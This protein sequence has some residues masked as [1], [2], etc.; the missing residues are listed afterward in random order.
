MKK[1]KKR[2]DLCSSWT[3]GKSLKKDPC[4]HSNHKLNKKKLLFFFFFLFNIRLFYRQSSY[5]WVSH[6]QFLSAGCWQTWAAAVHFEKAGKTSR[7]SPNR[8]SYLSS[9]V[10]PFP[11]PL[12]RVP[13][14]GSYWEPIPAA[15][16][17][18][19]IPVSPVRNGRT[20]VC[21]KWSRDSL[22]VRSSSC[23]CHWPHNFK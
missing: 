12:L 2:V 22:E 4:R 6:S 7:A 16:S 14:R 15:S 13:A 9:P 19:H 3:E 5:F 8:K 11:L 23:C 1:G 10:L 21:V 20:G 18:T 17:T